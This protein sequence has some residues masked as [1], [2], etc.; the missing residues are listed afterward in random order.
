MDFKESLHDFIYRLG[1]A[2]QST[3]QE[4]GSLSGKVD[5]FGNQAQ[6]YRRRLEELSTALDYSNFD[7]LSLHDYFSKNTSL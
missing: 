5:R 7:F 3:S 1:Q 2:L 4:L 6:D